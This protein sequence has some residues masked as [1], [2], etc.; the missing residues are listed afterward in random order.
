MQ[1]TWRSLIIFATLEQDANDYSRQI[2]TYFKAWPLVNLANLNGHNW[3]ILKEQRELGGSLIEPF[4]SLSKIDK[5]LCGNC[6]LKPC[7]KQKSGFVAAEFSEMLLMSEC[8]NSSRRIA[9]LNIRFL[10]RP[11]WKTILV[12]I[13]TTWYTGLEFVWLCT[14]H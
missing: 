14:P 6:V 8:G 7:L 2:Q 3:S 4:E 5:S 10:V 9:I 1:E 11:V 13:D 12:H